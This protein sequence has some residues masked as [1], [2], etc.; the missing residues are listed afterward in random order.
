MKKQIAPGLEVWSQ[1]S[2]NFS[3][4]VTQ[5]DTEWQIR[6]RSHIFSL[7]VNPQFIRSGHLDLVC[8]YHVSLCWVAGGL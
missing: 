1:D 7:L 6:L 3:H 8:S 5:S 4:L 2:Q